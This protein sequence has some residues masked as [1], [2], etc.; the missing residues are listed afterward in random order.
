MTEPNVLASACPL[1]CPDN[2]SL[3]VTVEN[4]RIVRVDGARGRNGLTD[5]YICS[6]VRRIARHVHGEERIAYPHRRTGGKGAGELER[7]G[8]DEALELVAARLVECRDRFGGE[9]I[10]PYSY[11]GSNGRLTQDTTDALLFSRLGASRLAR[12][13]CA[14]PT[15]LAAT[16]MT[17]KMPG[18]AL[19]DY[20]HARLIV[21][22]GA[23]PHA[24]GIHL[25]PIVERAR[26]RGAR[27]VVVDPRRTGLAARADLHL[28][29]RPGTDVVVALAAIRE[30]FA[31]GH[32]DLEF[33]A[34]HTTG[35]DELRRRAEPW[36]IARAAE[37]AGLDAADLRRF[38]DLYAASSP[39]VV[40]CGWGAERNRNGV[41]AI[42]AILALPAVAGKFGVRGGGFTMSNSG[43][44]RL[45]PGF[46]AAPGD[47][48]EINMNRLGEALTS[49]DSPAVRL[50]FV[51]DSNALAT[52]PNQNL[53]RRGLEREDLFTVV[54]DQVWTDTARW[55]DVVL[56]ATTF[57]EHRE[58]SRGYGAYS[59]HVAEPVIPPVGESRSN[60]AVF[61]ELA[62]RS[63]VAAEGEIPDERAT[64]ERLLDSSG[65][66]DALRA[67]LA[68]RGV[69]APPSGERPVQFGD[70]LP[71]TA[72]RRMRLAPA[73][74][75]G[76]EAAPLYGYLPEPDAGRLALISPATSRTISSTFGQ[77]G[78]TRVPIELHPDDAAA[79]GIAD[80]DR[81]RVWNELGEV[82]VPARLTRSV[83]PGVACLPKGLWSR[84]TENGSTANALAPDTLTAVGGGACFNDARIEVRR[85]DG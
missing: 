19:A 32:A 75:D 21:V 12:T 17:G 73:E 77:L 22:W 8:W 84:Q 45:D 70:V 60:Y 14:I 64:I 2:C 13:V 55:A 50:L 36:T 23:N 26:A 6:K 51:Y 65:R 29:L 33:L 61:A 82:V 47:T 74:L 59:L 63:G 18:V 3:D 27:L 42:A 53:V 68:E 72:D 38:V 40:R 35:A 37:V 1:D 10:L 48:R 69:A 20:E 80:G 16:A 24:T 25:V 78:P 7:I 5:G 57:L 30:L 49:L 85:L 81:V 39:A 31:G 71:A 52:T 54:F 34:A 56:P 4:D 43:A 15:G 28:A 66:G 79:R 83:R 9:S 46:G 62:R 44:W 41:S 11:G 76:G 58:V 67:E